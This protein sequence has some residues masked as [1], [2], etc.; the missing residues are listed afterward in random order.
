[1]MKTHR[2]RIFYFL[3][4][5]IAAVFC[6]C[7]RYTPPSESYQAG[8]YRALDGLSAEKPDA[9]DKGGVPGDTQ[10]VRERFD[11]FTSRIFCES[12]AEDPM[13]LHFTLQ[14]P[15]SFGIA[16]QDMHF[17][18][19]SHELLLEDAKENE[20]LLQELLSFD[21][22]LLTS[23][24]LYT[25]QNLKDTLE[26]EAL[27]KGLELLYQP[28]S[29]V[30]GVQAQL[31]V[32]L[33]EYEFS[34][35]QD[36]DDYL[37]LLAQIDTYYAQLADYEKERAA[38]GLTPCDDAIDRILI[39]CRD[40]LASPESSFMAETFESRLN[41]VPDLTDAERDAYKQANLKALQ[42]HFVPAYTNLSAALEALKGTGTGEQGLCHFEN[43]KA[44]YEYLVASLTGT[45]STAPELRQRIE[46]ELGSNMA[47]IG[48]LMKNH[49]ELRDSLTDFRFPVTDPVEIL[50]HL[51]EQIKE[52]FPE[53][54]DSGF[55]VKHVPK[56]LETSLSPAFFLIPPL[57]SNDTN[58]IYINDLLS[59]DDDL[60]TTLAHEGYPGHLYQSV[61]FNRRNPCPLQ[62]LLV[63]DGYSEGWGL[64]CELYAY[65]FDN[66][67]PEP[68]KQVV[69]QSAAS[70]YGL[71]ALLDIR[72]NYDGWDL[73]QTTVFLKTYYGIEDADVIAEI[74]HSLTDNPVNYLKYYTGFLEIRTLRDEAAKA[75]GERFDV[76]AFHQFIL[77]M[78]GAPFRVIR[79]RFQ[80]WLAER[81]AGRN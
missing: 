22:A 64:Y 46:K 3:I 18:S 67:N 32:L 5:M 50:N 54:D 69:A 42:E 45:G 19:I 35:K 73:D 11:A 7:S 23:S 13:S 39:S 6:G 74:Y 29:P 72:I 34:D 43:G 68:L 57:D 20:A 49:P 63:C 61:Y 76:K 36:V 12:L 41:E 62:R 9:P 16:A 25:W 60:Y 38:A 28:L 1:M 10:D 78:E 30:I 27:S 17:P 51:R 52:D 31:P 53:L 80:T 59:G 14:N 40:Y 47:Q 15:E 71:Y 37:A 66:G 24:Q 21:P 4:V 65:S 44:Y 2:N 33:A 75:L 56:A 79:P 26:T 48:L 55:E 58:V 8:E 81:G 70:I 77:D